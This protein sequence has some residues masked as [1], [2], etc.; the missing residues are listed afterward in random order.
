MNDN[1]KIKIVDGNDE[2]ELSTAPKENIKAYMVKGEPG[3]SSQ[4]DVVR[5]GSTV[6]LT[7]TDSRGSNSVEINDGVSPTVNTS[8]TDNVTTL[9]IEDIDGIRTAE[10]YDGIDL[11]G[12]VPTNGVIGFDGA[13]ADIPN[14][15]EV[16]TDPF[17]GSG[18]SSYADLPDKPQINSVE[19]SG[20]TS[21]SDLGII[22]GTVLYDNSTGTTGNVTLSESV[23]D[24]S[25][26]E[27]YY[28]R[29]HWSGNMYGSR[30]INDANGKTT[31]L[32]GELF[33]FDTGNTTL[34][35]EHKRVSLSGNTITVIDYG[36]ATNK[37]GGNA[38]S[39]T[40]YITKV[41]GYK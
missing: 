17:P 29:N 39:N 22:T 25:Y 15:Y 38:T 33:F 23:A 14:G 11:T 7:I 3:T 28:Y 24:Y 26:V 36:Q 18:T 8:R 34:Y 41:I 19:L 21:L 4:V 13:A 32:G 6:T 5:S 16:T 37:G 30:K 20:N 40:I 9:T 31:S 27:I 12:G 35:V 2:I 10:I 1:L